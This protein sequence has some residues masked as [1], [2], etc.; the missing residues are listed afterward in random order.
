LLYEVDYAAYSHRKEDSNTS[1]GL[2]FEALIEYASSEILSMPP[3]IS[4]IADLFDSEYYRVCPEIMSLLHLRFILEAVDPDKEVK[5]AIRVDAYDDEEMDLDVLL[6][7]LSNTLIRK[8][9]LYNKAFEPLFLKEEILRARYVKSEGMK[10]LN[11]C[12]VNRK[13]EKGLILER[14]TELLFTDGNTIEV[15]TKRVETGDEEIDLLIKNT[16]TS[17]FWQAFSSPLFFVECKNWSKPVGAKELRDFE[18]KIQNHSK[19]AKIGFF[20]SL[21]GFTSG[22]ES[23]M[24][25]CSRADYH[26]VTLSKTEIEDFLKTDK[27]FYKWLEDLVA[28]SFY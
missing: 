17:P 7:Q 9:G 14:L 25:R 28:T 26:I 8:V 4:E 24:K 22:F 21:N 15:V 18:I 13:Y 11:S 19:L 12:N 2:D 1:R 10:L 5:L 27:P 23:E 3:W 20:V 6:S 16:M